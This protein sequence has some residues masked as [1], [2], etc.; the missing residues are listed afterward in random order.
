MSVSGGVWAA[1][2]RPSVTCMALMFCTPHAYAWARGGIRTTRPTRSRSR[3]AARNRRT[4]SHPS[5]R[6][7]P[8][9]ATTTA[10]GSK[11]LE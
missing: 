9:N 10:S 3:T 6:S 7:R 4:E 11:W 8:M 2:Q 5:T 1:T